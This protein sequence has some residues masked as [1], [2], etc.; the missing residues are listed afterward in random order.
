MV[1]RIPPAALELDPPAVASTAGLCR[2]IA[3]A[4]ALVGNLDTERIEAAAKAEEFILHRKP[5][6]S[7]T[8]VTLTYTKG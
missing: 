1:S 6:G 8:S 4:L 3:A 7:G 5:M 2:R